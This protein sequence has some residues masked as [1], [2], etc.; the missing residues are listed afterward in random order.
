MNKFDKLKKT[1]IANYYNL[2]KQELCNKLNISNSTYYNWKNKLN[3]DNINS[4]NIIWSSDES[5]P[6]CDSLG[7]N[8]YSN[9][10]FDKINN[11]LFTY[12]KYD[13]K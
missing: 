9:L 1:F 12:R 2:S 7:I 10:Y 8:G 3:L 11:L 4:N 13:T 5:I 6:T